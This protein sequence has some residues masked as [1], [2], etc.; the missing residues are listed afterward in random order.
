MHQLRRHSADYL[1]HHLGISYLLF[2]FIQLQLHH[3][4]QIR[5]LYIVRNVFVV[6]NQ[7][8]AKVVMTLA[9]V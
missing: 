8:G 4:A 6:K 3:N 7:T 1:S 9:P 2:Q 5:T